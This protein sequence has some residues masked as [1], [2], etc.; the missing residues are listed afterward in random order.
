MV[1]EDFTN[2]SVQKKKIYIP[3]RLV[4]IYWSEEDVL[5]LILNNIF[6]FFLKKE[7]TNPNLFKCNAF[8]NIKVQTLEIEK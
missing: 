4:I 8:K 2:D 5:H 1:C 6:T 3:C 7:N